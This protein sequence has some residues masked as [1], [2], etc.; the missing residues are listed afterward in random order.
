M[1]KAPS[2][3]PSTPAHILLV[4]DNKMGLSARRIVL[5][6]L[7]YRITPSACARE[8]LE[9]FEKQSF[10]LMVTD[11][12]MPRMDGVELISHV[13]KSKPELPIILIS[14]FADTL[15]LDQKTTGADIVIQ[16]SNHEVPNLIHSVQ[17]LLSRKPPKSAASSLR[18]RRKS[19]S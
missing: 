2:R 1:T 8:A 18:G 14:G 16:K 9:Q 13:R 11:Y 15:G 7:G 5:E 4:D 10:D 3:K 6:E 12:R 17:R 19:A